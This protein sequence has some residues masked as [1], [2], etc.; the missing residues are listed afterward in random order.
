MKRTLT[1]MQSRLLA[2]ALLL[3]VIALLA[4]SVYVPWRQAHQHY[5][6]AIEEKLDRTARYL[7]IAAQKANVEAN[8]E[9]VRKQRAE[10]YYLT[11]SA[12]AL[13]AAE[14]QQ[15][16]LAIVEA[17]QVKVESTQIAAHKDEDARRKVTVNFRL[18]GP[19]PAMQK[20][21]YEL[22]TAAPY[23]YVDNLVFLST[24]TRVFRP[25]PGVEPDVQAQF[26]LYA[27]AR[28]GEPAVKKP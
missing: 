12:P 23:L 11:A 14:I 6:A 9:A 1:P 19:L 10:R 8:I 22:E 16:A 28:I 7:R 27:F 15:M 26:D 20:T 13:A 3:G 17:N 4:V 21:L 24:I 25:T 18:R 2:I 5:D